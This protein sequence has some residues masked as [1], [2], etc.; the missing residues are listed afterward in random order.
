MRIAQVISAEAAAALRAELVAADWQDGRVSAGSQAATVKR[1]RQLP[2]G[3][4]AQR[5]QAQV[6]AALER[7]P[8]FLSA[9]LPL[10]LFPPHINRY[11]VGE[12]YG[13]HVDGAVRLLADGTRLRTDLSATLFLSEPEDYDGGE[14]IVE[15]GSGIKLAAGDLVL[16]PA[17]QVHR[18]T[19]VTRGERLAAF[20]WV[21]SLVRSSEQRRLLFELDM[22]ILA[23][24]QRLG[25][26][27][28]TLR[29]MAVYHQLLQQWSET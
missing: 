12:H 23:L 17:T 28:E 16:Y 25:E 22:S 6:L 15:Q 14:L 1:N 8:L 7:H 13:D 9:A 26:D 4:L 10:R 5:V 27:G 24:R 11:G 21:Q 29:L 20:F 2:A 3:P 19:P 18:V